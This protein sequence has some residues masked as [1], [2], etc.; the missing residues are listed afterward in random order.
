MHEN[1][2]DD[3]MYSDDI[4]PESGLEISDE[5]LY[6]SLDEDTRNYLTDPNRKIYDD[7]PFEDDF[8]YYDEEGTYMGNDDS[9]N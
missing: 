6:E 5:E 9:K 8:P 3:D 4:D 2:E 7:F 1:N